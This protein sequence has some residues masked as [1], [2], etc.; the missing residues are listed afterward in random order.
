MPSSCSLPSLGT[1][2]SGTSLA[3][4]LRLDDKMTTHSDDA[5]AC[6]WLHTSCSNLDGQDEFCQLK[7]AT[8]VSLL[9]P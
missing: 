5:E 2:S 6:L 7:A 8:I 9:L 3:G 1:L 4:V